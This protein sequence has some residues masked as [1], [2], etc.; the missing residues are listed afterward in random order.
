M[1]LDEKS[2][3]SR[4]SRAARSSSNPAGLLEGVVVQRWQSNTSSALFCDFSQPTNPKAAIPVKAVF[5][6]LAWARHSR[7]ATAFSTFTAFRW[8]DS[9]NSRTRESSAPRHRRAA[10]L[11]HLYRVLSSPVRKMPAQKGSPGSMVAPKSTTPSATYDLLSPQSAAQSRDRFRDSCFY[12][13]RV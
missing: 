2:D 5:A 11:L 1:S 4:A 7:S 10:P 6:V 12:A 13:W 9:E 3:L 8:A